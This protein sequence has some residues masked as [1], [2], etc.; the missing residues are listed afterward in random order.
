MLRPGDLM[1]ACCF[2]L[3]QQNYSD[4][5]FHQR[6]DFQ[7]DRSGVNNLSDRIQSHLPPLSQPVVTFTANKNQVKDNKPNRQCSACD[8]EK[9]CQYSK[10]LGVIMP[11]QEHTSTRLQDPF[12]WLLSHVREK[13]SLKRRS[14]H[15]DSALIFY[16]HTYIYDVYSHVK[17]IL[18]VI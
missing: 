9:G 10:V 6:P 11:N 8:L 5:C 16:I 15:G 17:K 2:P 18:S 4:T 14:A 13:M 12:G 1:G 7:A 3:S